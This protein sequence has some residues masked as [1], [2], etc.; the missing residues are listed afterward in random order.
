MSIIHTIKS[1]PSLKKFVHWTLIPS[2]Q[3]R[4]RLWVK[5][6]VN[7]FFHKVSRKSTI[8]WNTRMDVLPFNPFELGEGS[9][10]E[11]FSTINN[12]VGAVKI[13]QFSRVGIGNVIIGP[14]S[15]GN[16][17]ILAQNIVMSGLNHG[18]E[19]INLPIHKQKVSMQPI[20]IEDDSWIGANVVVT[21]GVTIG[22]HSVVAAG[23]VVTKSIPP[24]SI[25]V[26]NPARVIKQY[27]ANSGVW[28][29]V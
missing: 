6:F 5:W 26:G 14:V 1:N 28:E 11:D 20:F 23:A 17:V 19:D 12:G 16:H 3:A 8:R 15:I 10:I 4:P 2:G 29:R 22:K 21:A 13:G 7:P 18:Y 9:T 24:F 25:A 27:N